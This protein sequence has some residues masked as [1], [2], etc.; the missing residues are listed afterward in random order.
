M[1]WTDMNLLNLEVNFSLIQLQKG[2]VLLITQ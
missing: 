1:I 2:G